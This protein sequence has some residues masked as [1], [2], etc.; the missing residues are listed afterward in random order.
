MKSERANGLRF[1][2]GRRPSEISTNFIRDLHTND[3]DG[4]AQSGRFS[5]GGDP[6]K[7]LATCCLPFGT[8]R[9]RPKENALT[10]SRS[11]KSVCLC[12]AASVPET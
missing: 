4:C 2:L 3:L 9:G 7:R 1:A 5:D 12:L 6:G 10:T 11:Y 8:R